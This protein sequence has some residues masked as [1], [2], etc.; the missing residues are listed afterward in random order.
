MV[1]EDSEKDWMTFVEV[2]GDKGKDR[3]TF[4]KIERDKKRMVLTFVLWYGV[5]NGLW[6]TLDIWFV[7]GIDCIG[8]W[9]KVK[10]IK[11]NE[12]DF[13]LDRKSIVFNW[14]YFWKLKLVLNER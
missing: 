12:K 13:D 8:L 3:M 2:E 14:K 11:E 9:L 1:N 10:E 6:W 4:V 7:F 5:R